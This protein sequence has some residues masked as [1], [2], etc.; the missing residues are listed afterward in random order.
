MGPDGAERSMGP[1][2]AASSMGP[3]GAERSMGPEGAASSMGPDGAERSM[4]PE[5]AAADE[6]SLR[7]HCRRDLAAYKVPR[8]IHIAK[9]LP[10]GPTGKVLKRALREQLRGGSDS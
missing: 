5:G 6:T 4:G 8:R 1:E 10:R 3:D 9:E 7:E 2:G